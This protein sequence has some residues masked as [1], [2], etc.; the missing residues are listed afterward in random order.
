[1]KRLV[2]IHIR[3]LNMYLLLLV[4]VRIAEMK[5]IADPRSGYTNQR[6]CN[7]NR[8]TRFTDHTLVQTASKIMLEIY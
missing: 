3:Y 7:T 8:G 1:M 4:I 5:Y 6:S 2:A